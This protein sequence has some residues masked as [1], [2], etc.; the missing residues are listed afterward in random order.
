MLRSTII[1]PL[2]LTIFLVLNPIR[3]GLAQTD[4]VETVPEMD[5]ELLRLNVPDAFQQHSLKL[6]IFSDS[7]WVLYQGQRELTF[8][9]AMELLGQEHRLQAWEEH[10]A[11]EALFSAD[12]RARRVFSSVATLVGGTYLLFIWDKGW[13]YQIPGYALLGVA[14]IRYWESHK[15]QVAARRQRYYIDNII[16]PSELQALVDNYNL[17]LY[18]FLSK[19][20]I[21]YR[22]S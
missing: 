12:H 11:Q 21:R 22:D 2:L 5:F 8:V 3:P 9:E 14:G 13:L 17:R 10:Q 15:A 1:K 7:S 19:T 16:R 20:G 6:E 4:S 18:Q